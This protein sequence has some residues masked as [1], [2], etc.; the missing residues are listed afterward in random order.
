MSTEVGKEKEEM[1][2]VG[3]GAR[4]KAYERPQNQG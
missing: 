2:V 4:K 1:N 3:K